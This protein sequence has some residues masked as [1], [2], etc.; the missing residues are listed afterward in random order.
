EGEDGPGNGGVVDE[1]V[2]EHV[3]GDGDGAAGEADVGQGDA[4][5]AAGRAAGEP[6]AGHH[7]ADHGNEEPA[8][9][10]F[11]Q[12]QDAHDEGG[13][14]GDEEAQGGEVEGAGGGQAAEAGVAQGAGVVAQQVA[15]GRR[16]P[17][18]GRQGFR[19]P[20]QAGDQQ[21]EREQHQEPEDRRPARPAQYPAADDRGD[22]G[23][24]AEDHRDL[25]EQALGVGAVEQ[26]TDH[27][28]AHYHAHT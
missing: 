13:G 16:A 18:G 14:G 10:A 25:A 24:D 2:I 6:G 9:L 15:R 3:A 1:E 8:E 20:A 5:D 12:P 17:L 11:A 7:A 4:P 22:G 21:R 27:R 23:G 19:K 26:V 28:P